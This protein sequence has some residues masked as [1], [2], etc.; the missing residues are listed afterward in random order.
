MDC[1]NAENPN[2]NFPEQSKQYSLMQNAHYGLALKDEEIDYENKIENLGAIGNYGSNFDDSMVVDIGEDVI[3]NNQFYTTLS[4]APNEGILGNLS[5]SG[6]D[7]DSLFH[8]QVESITDPELRDSSSITP[9]S[10]HNAVDIESLAEQVNLSRQYYEKANYLAFANQEQN[11]TYNFAKER[12]DLLMQLNPAL[13]QHNEG[14]MQQL[15]IHVQL[16]QRQQ[17]LSPG[18]PFA[19]LD[20]PT[21]VS[22]PS[23]GGNN[24][25][26]SNNHIENSALSPAAA[27]SLKKG[28]VNDSKIQILQQRVSII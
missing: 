19:N 24:S 11:S 1:E 18:F 9:D 3:D 6:E 8:S 7:L 27:V 22:L 12:P 23:P 13:L 15:Q 16:Q 25:L 20:S 5:D 2:T 28:S 26:D 21:G 10:V 4:F 17:I 14:Q